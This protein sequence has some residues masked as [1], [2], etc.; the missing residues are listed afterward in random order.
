MGHNRIK[1][2][3]DF[4]RDF[5]QRKAKIKNLSTINHETVDLVNFVIKYDRD[6]YLRQL[7]HI[8]VSN[9]SLLEEMAYTLEGV[10]EL[11]D[12]VLASND[13]SKWR[14]NDILMTEWRQFFIPK[15]EWAMNNNKRRA[16]RLHGKQLA[17]VGLMKGCLWYDLAAVPLGIHPKMHE[18]KEENQHLEKTEGKQL[19]ER[20]KISPHGLSKYLS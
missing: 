20:V 19:A 3:E 2:A 8:F 6:R 12:E 10:A 15:M 14:D 7:K 17:T 9:R 1:E 11:Y 5:D 18:V 4:E 13:I 16:L